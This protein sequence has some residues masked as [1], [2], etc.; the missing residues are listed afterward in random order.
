MIRT[1]G[2]CRRPSINFTACKRVLGVESA[3]ATSTSTNSVVVSCA[4]WLRRSLVT[5][6]AAGCSASRLET[7]AIQAAVSTKTWRTELNSS[8]SFRKDNGRAHEPDRECQYLPQSRLGDW[9]AHSTPRHCRQTRH[10]HYSTTRVAD[11]TF[12]ALCVS[13]R[14]LERPQA[15]S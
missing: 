6:W 13:H 4:R 9:R 1:A 15:P 7:S 3:L 12:L 10:Y 5:C 8:S 2:N 14:H 11:I